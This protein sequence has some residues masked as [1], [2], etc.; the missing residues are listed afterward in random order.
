M[1]RISS[2]LVMW[3]IGG[4]HRPIPPKARTNLDL[5]SFSLSK[6]DIVPLPANSPNLH[7]LMQKIKSDMCFQLHICTV[8]NLLTIC[9][10]QTSNFVYRNWSYKQISTFLVNYNTRGKKLGY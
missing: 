5:L 9:I 3:D 1:V 6:V 10:I 8:V 4:E 7:Q 2:G